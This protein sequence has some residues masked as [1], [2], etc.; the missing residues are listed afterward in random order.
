M[1]K[2]FHHKSIKRKQNKSLIINNLLLC[3]FDTF[4]SEKA[5]SKLKKAQELRTVEIM[6]EAEFLE[7]VDDTKE[8]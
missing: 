1:D 4:C 7:K 8:E 3:P 2:F 6:T 5:G